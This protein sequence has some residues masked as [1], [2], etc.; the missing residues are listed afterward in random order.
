MEDVSLPPVLSLFLKYKQ[1]FK[2]LPMLWRSAPLRF[3]QPPQECKHTSKCVELRRLSEQCGDGVQLH[4]RGQ[5]GW[6]ASPHSCEPRRHDWWPGAPPAP[7]GDSIFVLDHNFWSPAIINLIR[8]VAQ[9]DDN[10]FSVTT[11]IWVQQKRN[12]LTETN[13]DVVYHRRAASWLY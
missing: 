1:T 13:A 5:E 9:W 8:L 10:I 6:A 11:N 7:C 12:H 3:S 4:C 2:P